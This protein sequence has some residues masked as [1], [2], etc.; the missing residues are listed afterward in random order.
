MEINASCGVFCL[1]YSMQV[2]PHLSSGLCGGDLGS[3]AARAGVHAENGRLLAAGEGGGLLAVAVLL[4]V[5]IHASEIEKCLVSRE[6][7]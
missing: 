1:Q 2:I 7:Q 6:I 3:G 5:L 4:G